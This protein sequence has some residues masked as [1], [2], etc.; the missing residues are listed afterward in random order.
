M[1]L[2]CTRGNESTLN[3]T[4]GSR[5]RPSASKHR[6]SRHKHMFRRRSVPPNSTLPPSPFG[7]RRHAS[8]AAVVA[9]DDDSGPRGT[10]TATQRDVRLTAAVRP[11]RDGGLEVLVS[12]EWTVF[13]DSASAHKKL[14][15][16]TIHWA[17]KTCNVDERLPHC[18]DPDAY[19]S[20]T[21]WS[22]GSKVRIG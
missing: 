15:E 11:T 10:T 5:D 8:T 12:W 19:Y 20:N 7:D 14:F 3:C 6:R 13:R 1:K 2:Q 9:A 18:D 4:G 16:F 22:H 21:V 17:R